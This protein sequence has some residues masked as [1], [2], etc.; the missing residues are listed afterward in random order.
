[1]LR[2]C[3]DILKWVGGNV[4]NGHKMREAMIDDVKLSPTERK[5]ID[6]QL[7]EIRTRLYLLEEIFSKE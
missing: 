7:E 5:K 4:M 3:H 2:E 1:M 6:K